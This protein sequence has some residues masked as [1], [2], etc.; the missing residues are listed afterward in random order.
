MNFEKR[1]SKAIRKEAKRRKK[2]A[3]EATISREEYEL[4]EDY[5]DH[6]YVDFIEDQG[7]KLKI[8]RKKPLSERFEDSVWRM[9]YHIEADILPVGRTII[10]YDDGLTKQID[11]LYA[12]ENHVYVVECKWRMKKGGLPQKVSNLRGELQKWRG[13]LPKIKERLQD[14]DEFADKDVHFLLVTRGVELTDGVKNEGRD[15]AYFLDD[16]LVDQISDM[17]KK[18]GDGARAIL[19]QRLFKGQEIPGEPR[20]FCATKTKFGNREV[21]SFFADAEE[22]IDLAYVHRREPTNVDL[23]TA[24]QRFLKPNK[25][26]RISEYVAQDGNFFPNSIVVAIDDATYELAS[27]SG[28]ETSMGFLTLPNVYGAVWIID[29]QH[30]LYGSAAREETRSKKMPVVAIKGLTEPE[31]GEI[32]RIINEKQTRISKNLLWDLYGERDPGGEPVT[33]QQIKGY[34]RKVISLLWKSI[35][36]SRG[37]PL[38]GK[39]I[40]PSQTTKSEDCF[41][42]F[43]FLCDGLDY[44]DL[45]QEGRLRAHNWK[46]A[47]N[48]ARNRISYFFERLAEEF[49]DEW[50][51]GKES[52]LL[53]QYSLRVIL[54][55]LRHG[56]K[57]FATPRYENQWKRKT[58]FEGLV[59]DFVETLG[60]AIRSPST[61]YPRD[62]KDAANA[63]LRQRMTKLVIEEMRDTY[64]DLAPNLDTEIEEEYGDEPSPELYY[65]SRDLELAFR[66]LVY[67]VLR[68]DQGKNWFMKIPNDI[69]E[70]VEKDVELRQAYGSTE[71]GTNPNR[72][73]L[74]STTLSDLHA[75]ITGEKNWELFKPHLGDVQKAFDEHFRDFTYLRNIIAHGKKYPSDE[76]RQR[77]LAALDFLENVA[78]D[79][80]DLSEA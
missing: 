25:V 28:P 63:S 7:D 4:D 80:P 74:D 57:M 50:D 69:R 62:I 60:E 21:Y 79:F 30:R 23:S 26:A 18:M 19:H 27:R 42:K 52:W 48:F 16:S 70:K 54:R 34:R 71:L 47:E 37:H 3:F 61:E 55:V 77:W 45:W 68:E 33:T 29:G 66:D 41:I 65:R 44:E 20:R 12:D 31:Q 64:P 10:E 39:I 43:A 32:F 22:L 24:Y 35:N 49:P 73:W 9:F 76:A 53:S 58:K 14:F 11:G 59:D 17:A 5:Y 38:A 40:I 13:I 2:D 56:I 72:E 78:E 1:A 51:E 15:F 46:T 36:Q 8:K 6:K 75:I 67:H